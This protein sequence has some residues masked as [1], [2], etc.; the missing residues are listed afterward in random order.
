MNIIKW[1]VQN[2]VYFNTPHIALMS[3]QRGHIDKEAVAVHTPERALAVGL[4]QAA[5]E[6]MIP[7][8][9]SSLYIDQIYEHLEMLSF[10]HWDWTVGL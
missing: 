6:H 4:V 5:T 9:R 3:D 10:S 8:G 1:K 7:S 2:S